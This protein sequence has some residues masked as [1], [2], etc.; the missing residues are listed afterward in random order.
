MKPNYYLLDLMF[1]TRPE[2]TDIKI[3]NEVI[4]NDAYKIASILKHGDFVIDIG[5]HI[6]SFSIYAASLGAKVLAF[7]P[8]T[9]NF[10]LL[11]VNIELN[12]SLV[13]I[14][15]LGIMD[16][17]GEKTL[18]IREIN[19]GGTSFF[20]TAGPSEIVQTVTLKE[21]FDTENI[22][23]CDFLKIDCE[24][25]EL[26]ILS[27]FPY[28]DRVKQLAFEYVGDAKVKEMFMNLIKHHGYEVTSESNE[29]MG[30][31]YGVR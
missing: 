25:A 6:G 29:R 14:Q 19:F 28:F 16:T 10:D 5:A 26:N 3:V 7:E 22:E 15:K 17:G 24:G 8:A 13:D 27:T 2:T 31:I 12:N 23:R 21:V 20:N 11:R 18:I 9:V 4:A 30:Y 1:V